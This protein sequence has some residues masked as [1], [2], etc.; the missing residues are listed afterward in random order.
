MD[1][2]WWI[3]NNINKYFLSAYLMYAWNLTL[4]ANIFSNNFV[5]NNENSKWDDSVQ[6]KS[7]SQNIN[8]HLSKQQ[9]FFWVS[10]FF[11]SSVPNIYIKLSTVILNI[12]IC[13]RNPSSHYYNMFWCN[14]CI[15]NKQWTYCDIII[16][17]LI[18]TIKHQFTFLLCCYKK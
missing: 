13:Q 7:C 10:N 5:S 6:Y 17:V 3:P 12:K 15:L 14:H 2:G 18:M 8:N 11:R 9:I 1:F 16:F 4:K